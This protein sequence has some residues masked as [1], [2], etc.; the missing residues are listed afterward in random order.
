MSCS[1]VILRFAHENINDKTKCYRL[2][3]LYL[4]TCKSIPVHISVRGSV[5]LAVSRVFRVFSVA[6]EI[7]R[8]NV[9][10]YPDICESLNIHLSDVIQLG[11]ISFYLKKYFQSP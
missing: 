7:F 5:Y 9:S 1:L 10:N 6:K 2:A 11:E 3:M 8:Q 4:K